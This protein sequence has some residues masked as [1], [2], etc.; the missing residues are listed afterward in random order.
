MFWR[1]IR[2]AYARSAAGLATVMVLLC[3][4]AA[5]ASPADAEFEALAQEYL[6]DLPKFSPV[7]ATLI[8]DHSADDK[9]DQVD[10]RARSRVRTLYKGLLRKLSAI[11]RNALSRAN[12]VDAELLR[13]ELEYEVWSI[14]T[15]Q[16]WAWDPLVYVPLAG[17][18]IYGL[19]ARDFA[20]LDIRLVAAAARL[21]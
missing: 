10:A 16:E 20:P 18:S 9:L 19:V 12:Q 7:N 14:D 21:D 17:S 15:F 2:T 11:D 4:G 1:M 3:G 13:N 8:G 6:A 5:L